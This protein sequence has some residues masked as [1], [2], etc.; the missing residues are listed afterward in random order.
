MSRKGKVELP[1]SFI[2]SEIL[3]RIT[4]K[5]DVGRCRCV[6]KQWRSFL[7]TPTFARMHLHHHA[8]IDDYKLLLLDDGAQPPP[9]LPNHDVYTLASLDGLVC[10][11]PKEGRGRESRRL[12]F[13]N[14][15]TGL[16]RKL[17][18]M[19]DSSNDY[20]LVYFV[21][22]GSLGAYI[23]SHRLD[24]WRE[25]QFPFATVSRWSA[26]TL[27][28]QCLYFTVTWFP[29]WWIISVHVETETF[30]RIGSGTTNCPSSANCGGWMVMVM[31]G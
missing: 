4:G 15:L 1:F 18:P 29:H 27:C 13:W 24:S 2:E 21:S 14:P 30:R 9:R 25:I 10:L 28:G 7:S 11:A 31:G 22:G 19:R 6:C 12:V 16:H 8:T 23:Y 17:A 26:A 20:K 3:P 5:S